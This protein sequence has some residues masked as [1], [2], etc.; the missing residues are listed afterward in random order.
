MNWVDIGIGI[1]IA[2][3]ALNVIVLRD[4]CRDKVPPSTRYRLLAP[5]ASRK[6]ASCLV[7]S[8]GQAICPEPKP[9]IEIWPLAPRV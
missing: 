4:D 1:G 5:S 6:L 8:G 2:L 9:N 7:I 3:K